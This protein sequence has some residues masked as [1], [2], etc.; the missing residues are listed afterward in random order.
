MQTPFSRLGAANGSGILPVGSLDVPPGKYT[1][2]LVDWETDFFVHRWTLFDVATGVAV[3]TVEEQGL[4]LFAQPSGF[5]GDFV[6]RPSLGSFVGGRYELIAI[7]AAGAKQNAVETSSD[8]GYPVYAQD[9]RGGVVVI[10]STSD[11]PGR[12]RVSFQRYDE[13][14]DAAT[15]QVALLSGP[16]DRLPNEFGFPV[17]P[18]VQA[19]VN[20]RGQ[21]LVMVNGSNL[22]PGWVLPAC[23]LFWVDPTGTVSTAIGDGSIDETCFW[24]AADPLI[25]GSIALQREIG[26]GYAAIVRDGDTKLE[27]VP[28]WLTARSYVVRDG[29]G[30]ARPSP[31]TTPGSIQVDVLTAHGRVCETL[32][33]AAP[34]LDLLYG[35]TIGL[36]GTLASAYSAGFGATTIRWWPQLFR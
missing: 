23:S 35:T 18:S 9:R 6:I 8:N 22:G 3:S 15:A 13:H 5:I 32:S 1:P 4:R 10:R 17:L 20:L 33:F 2:Q 31:T 28:P 24:R 34:G 27:P 36:D 14:G 16:T 19:A 30:Y 12:W 25:D 21:T 7:D 11:S 26:P 29:R